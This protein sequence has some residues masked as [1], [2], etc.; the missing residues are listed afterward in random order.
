M[1]VELDWFGMRK[2]KLAASEVLFLVVGFP[3]FATA[4]GSKHNRNGKW[5]NILAKCGRFQHGSIDTFY[6]IRRRTDIRKNI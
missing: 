5:S 1:F 4:E 3:Y 2:N 6:Y